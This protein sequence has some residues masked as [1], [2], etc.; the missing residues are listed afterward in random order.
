MTVNSATINL[1]KEFEGLSLTPYKDQAG[2]LTIGWGH[3]ILPG[4]RFTSI[5]EREAE[6]LLRKDL[7]VAELA[8]RAMTHHSINITAPEHANRFGA[9]VS[10]AF[11][12]GR[13]AY[14]HST[15]RAKVNAKDYEEAARQFLRWVYVTDPVTGQKVVSRGLQRRRK[16]EAALFMRPV[17]NV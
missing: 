11:N 15:L 16:A 9:L 6:N 12:V 10:F 8:V 14:R 4:E 7:S 13:D 1:I 2:K 3:L 5:T 17:D